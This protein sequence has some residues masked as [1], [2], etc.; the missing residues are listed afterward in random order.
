MDTRLDLQWKDAN[1][2]TQGP[3]KMEEVGGGAGA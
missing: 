3:W 2:Q 1:I